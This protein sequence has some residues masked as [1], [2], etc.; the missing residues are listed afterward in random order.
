MKYHENPNIFIA[1]DEIMEY[2][3][4]WHPNVN[5]QFRMQLREVIL[6]IIIKNL[7]KEK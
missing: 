2:Y 1:V 6:H 7:T 5:V 3:D 4:R